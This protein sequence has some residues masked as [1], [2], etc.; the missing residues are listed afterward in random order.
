M[1][2]YARRWKLWIAVRYLVLGVCG[3]MSVYYALQAPGFYR[4]LF[5]YFVP[6]L[7]VMTGVLF[8]M[9]PQPVVIPGLLLLLFGILI[10]DFP[11]L[12]R[13]A[14]L[15]RVSLIAL[16]LVEYL[17]IIAKRFF[18]YEEMMRRLLRD[19]H[20]R[21]YD[22]RSGPHARAHRGEEP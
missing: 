21:K 15:F 20:L 19:R 13:E 2:I 22:H 14:Q 12:T 11:D 4:P 7:C 8:W 16:L 10:P 18:N 5:L 17:P 3:V 1:D 6:G 9:L